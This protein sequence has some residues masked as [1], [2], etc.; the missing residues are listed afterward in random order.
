MP[1]EDQGVFHDR[2]KI[3]PRTLIF[4]T[5]EDK[6]LLLKG[7]ATKKLWANLYNGIGGHIERGEDI[8]NAARRE[9]KEE[10]G[11]E[12]GQLWLCGTIM[13]D[14]GGSTGIGIYVFRGENP[15]GE[16]IASGEGILEW[17]VIN[18]IP[19]LP[20]VEDLY[21][22]LPHFL[23]WKPGKPILFFRYFY[24]ENNQLKIKLSN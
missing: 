5:K 17:K 13:I 18:D 12:V 10:T 7:A 24:D 9:L 21:C 11:L 22:V 19:N 15:N 23:N 2:Y 16:M 20:M 4:L 14:T 3:I 1:K 8:L 6:V